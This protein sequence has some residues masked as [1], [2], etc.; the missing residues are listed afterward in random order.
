[1]TVYIVLENPA[2]Q[3]EPPEEMDSLVL[4]VFADK[5][6]ADDCLRH[7]AAC[8]LLRSNVKLFFEDGIAFDESGFTF[9]EIVARD[10]Q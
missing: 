7:H 9:F 3:A 5:K 6:N 10:I 8:V 1:M 2:A 4:G